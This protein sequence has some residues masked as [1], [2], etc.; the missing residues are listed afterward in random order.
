MGYFDKPPGPSHESLAAVP[1][2][3][4]AIHSSSLA[5]AMFV[6]QGVYLYGDYWIAVWSSKSEAEQQEVCA[7]MKGT[8][9]CE[10][11][12]SVVYGSML[13]PPTPFL[14]PSPTCAPPSNPHQAFW[15]WGYA[16]MVSCVLAISLVR[17]Q[18]FFH[19]TLVASS[20]MH[21]AMIERVSGV[22]RMASHAAV[23]L[24][25]AAGKRAFP[26]ILCLT[27]PVKQA[28]GLPNTPATDHD[29]ISPCR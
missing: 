16:I 7:G 17:A 25:T 8:R 14:L 11:V 5:A 18:L 20:A 27:H 19:Y 6:G 2:H 15:I 1:V 22:V 10:C 13:P 21:H 24:G 23:A 28:R 26:A 4:P 9:V 3:K 29:H 12:D